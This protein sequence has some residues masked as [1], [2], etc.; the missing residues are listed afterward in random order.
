MDPFEAKRQK[1]KNDKGC[2][3]CCASWIGV[4]VFGVLTAVGLL[5]SVLDLAICGGVYSC[6]S[7]ANE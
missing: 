6:N 7:Y 4:L 3:L 2:C 5:N 1:I